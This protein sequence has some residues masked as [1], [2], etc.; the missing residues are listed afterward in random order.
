M[1]RFATALAAVVPDASTNL[2]FWSAASSVLRE[3]RRWAGQNPIAI[4]W[5]CH[6]AMRR[7]RGSAPG[8]EASA[9]TVGSHDRIAADAAKC[10]GLGVCGG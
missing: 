5:Y 8:F 6:K 10:W 4:F 9:G 2:R 1:S 7:S 3:G